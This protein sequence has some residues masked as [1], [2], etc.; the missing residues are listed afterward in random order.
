MPK[1]MFSNLSTHPA[2][3]PIASE[4]RKGRHEG[5]FFEGARQ[6]FSRAVPVVSEF[7]PYAI[8][9]AG[10]SASQ[11]SGVLRELFTHFFLLT[12]QHNEK[13][14]IAGIEALFDELNEPR[15]M[16]LVAFVR[17]R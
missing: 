14:E 9:R 1:P 6:F 5:R 11:F 16:C 4:R 7:W 17:E 3:S 12:G 10:M 8:R 15:Q 2:F 13:R